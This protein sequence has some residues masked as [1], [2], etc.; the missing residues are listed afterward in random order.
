MTSSLPDK[1]WCDVF[2][3]T[4]PDWAEASEH[5]ES[6]SGRAAGCRVRGISS[7]FRFLQQQM[8]NWY[9]PTKSTTVFQ[10]ILKLLSQMFSL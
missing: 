6:N 10:A 2:N 1:V 3:L 5:E 7:Q 8:N 9:L 4:F